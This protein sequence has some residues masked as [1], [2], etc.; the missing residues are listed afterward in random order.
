MELKIQSPTMLRAAETLTA[1]LVR[2]VTEETRRALRR[3]IHE[4]M[5]DG[6]APIDAA[7]LI[8]QT[9]GLTERQALS[10]RA[11]RATN[12]SAAVGY[13]DKLLRQRAMNIARTETMRGANRGQQIAWREMARD[14]LMPTVRQR[15]STAPDDRLCDLCA[16]M[17]G[18]I[19]GL[20][21]AFESNERGVLPSKRVP[22]PVAMDVEGPPLHPS[23][24]C[25][26]GVVFE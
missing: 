1:D 24:R 14:P 26:L 16:P 11:I 8:R 2:D 9:I 25:T 7:R 18:K 15:W 5:R 23:C 4:S 12:P 20:D 6:I 3:I 22:L 10:V 13:A 17:D 19:I 21:A